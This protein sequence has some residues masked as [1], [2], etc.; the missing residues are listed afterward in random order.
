[1]SRPRRP[2]DRPMKSMDAHGSC[3][4]CVTLVVHIKAAGRWVFWL[5]GC[6]LCVVRSDWIAGAAIVA[7]SLF[8]LASQF[9]AFAQGR[10]AARVPGASSDARF[11]RH[12]LLRAVLD[13][14]VA[15]VSCPLRP[16]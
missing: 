1:M 5:P 13:A 16:L 7:D 4:V 3:E 6:L 11:R 9:K 10:F 14:V 12:L 15:F 8:P 2:A